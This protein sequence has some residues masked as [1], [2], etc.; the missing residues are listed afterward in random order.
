[1]ALYFLVLDS[2]VFHGHIR[3]ALA[4]SWRNRSFDPCRAYCAQ[5]LAAAQ[6]F[7]DK[8]HVGGTP[9]VAQI[10]AGLAFDRLLWHH[11]AGELLWFSAAEIPE[12]ETNE[13]ALACL[14]MGQADPSSASVPDTSSTAQTQQS[15][16][17]EGTP[18]PELPP[19]LQAHRGSRD[20]IFGGG[21]YRPENAG[22]NDASDV[23]RLAAF[24]QAVQP[25]TWQ[26]LDLAGVPELPPDEWDAELEYVRDWL[27]ALQLLYSDAA[28]RNQVIVCESLE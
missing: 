19:A 1:M 24:L 8:Y 18:R 15:R 27:P 11:L 12:L 25:E 17:Y 20:L 23:V 7:G 4:A 14:L 21:F 28:G 13:R 5:L 26:P 3:P 16:N 10:A 22:W 9:L 6:S 2:E